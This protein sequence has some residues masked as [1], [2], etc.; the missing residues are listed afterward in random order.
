MK[1]IK[2]VSKPK[3]LERPVIFMAGSI[4]MG[5]AEDW[6][7]SVI[8]RMKGYKGTLLNPRR[9]DWDNTWKQSINNDKFVEQVEWEL[10]GLKNSD[11]V[12]MYFSP[13]TKSPIT[14]LELGL[15][16]NTKA[17]EQLYICCPKGFWRKGN[18]D[19]TC[20]QNKVI[21]YSSLDNAIKVGLQRYLTLDWP[22]SSYFIRNGIM[23]DGS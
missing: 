22:L 12:F 13:G 9:D 7:E 20:K 18:V 4:D 23:F 2:A 19:I 21:V 6:Q 5:E 8:E 10:L 15:I 17:S 14:L 3:E 16:V 1:V 11:L